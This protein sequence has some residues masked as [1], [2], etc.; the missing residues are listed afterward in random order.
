L[1]IMATS[2]ALIHRLKSDAAKAELQA[3]AAKRRVRAAKAA[4]KQS[5]KLYKAEKKAA[6]Q[7]RKKFAAARTMA[8][9]RKPEPDLIKP[10]RIAKG[11]PS[12][13]AP[14]MK[15]AAAKA[16]AVKS[17]AKKR[18]RVSRKPRRAPKLLAPAAP[19]PMRSAADVAKSVIQR[20]QSPAP[21]PKP[22]AP[23]D[24]VIGN[25][26]PEVNS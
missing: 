6:K 2:K 13:K 1:K 20:L 17:N 7:A 3:A 10:S 23:A 19:D 5:R 14:R 26:P 15:S 11:A 18:A 12:A 21:A 22:A 9:T 16:P 25:E 24:P 4:L 8:L